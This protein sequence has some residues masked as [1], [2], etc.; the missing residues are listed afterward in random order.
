MVIYDPEGLQIL[1]IN[2]SN[3]IQDTI[4]MIIKIHEKADVEM[5][6]KLLKNN[7][8]TMT[9]TQVMAEAQYV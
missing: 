3:E 6:S 8:T 9:Q 2:A 1:L 7:V 4:L 5:V